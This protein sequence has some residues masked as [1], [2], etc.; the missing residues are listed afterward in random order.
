MFA[1]FFLFSVILFGSFAVSA[2][3][4]STTFSTEQFSQPNWITDKSYTVTYTI[5]KPG[6]YLLPSRETTVPGLAGN[7][8]F[9]SFYKAVDYQY[10]FSS[11]SKKYIRCEEKP[12]SNRLICDLNKIFGLSESEFNALSPESFARDY[13]VYNILSADWHYYS[14]P[15]EVE[16]GYFPQMMIGFGEGDDDPQLMDAKLKEGWNMIIYPPYLGYEDIELGDCKIEKAYIWVEGVNGQ[17]WFSIISNPIDDDYSGAGMVIK[18]SNDCT[19]L[20]EKDSRV[21]EPP[22]IPSNSGT[23]NQPCTDSDGG[24]DYSVKGTAIGGYGDNYLDACVSG[25]PSDGQLI[26]YYCGE[27]TSQSLQN[28]GNNLQMEKYSCPNGCSNGVCI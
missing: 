5:T 20:R 25:G 28:F 15:I 11:F 19:F 22:T 8:D 10:A 1:G 17:E 21:A 18:V 6:W 16:Y 24:K 12:T 27:T 9:L 26:E 7:T 3:Y 2:D 13:M 23:S 4:F 14:K